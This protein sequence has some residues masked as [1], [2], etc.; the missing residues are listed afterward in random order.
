MQRL[1]HP[2]KAL[3]DWWFRVSPDRR[4]DRNLGNFCMLLGLMFPTAVIM[5]TGPSPRT[6]LTEM[7]RW[8][9]TWMCAFIFLGC[10]LK[11]HGVLAG[12][13]W[14]FPKMTVKRC[15]SFGFIGAPFASSGLLVYGYFLISSVPNWIAAVS[16]VLTPMLGVGIGLQGFIYWLEYRRIDHNEA[17]MIEQAKTIIKVANDPNTLD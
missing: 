14:Y 12:T 13:R 5:L 17:I 7:S 2:V 16:T 3:D 8:L 10:L 4:L 15:Y 11:M 6:A 9:Q 1:L